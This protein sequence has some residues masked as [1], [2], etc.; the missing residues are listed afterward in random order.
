MKSPLLAEIIPTPRECQWSPGALRLSGSFRIHH[1]LGAAEADI[2][3]A[4]LL[5]G[6]LAEATGLRLRVLPTT[7]YV[8]HHVLYVG[9][10]DGFALG[11]A[12][13]ASAA[14]RD[15]GRS[16]FSADGKTGESPA[17]VPAESESYAAFVDARGVLLAGADSAGLF[18]AV[19]TLAQILRLRR[20]AGPAVPRVAIRDW[21][22]LP[23]RAVMIDIARQ[24]ER[25]DWM[26]QFVRRLAA[27]KKNMFVLYFEDKFRWGKH[28]RLSHPLGYSADEF[29]RLAATAEENHMEFVPALASLGH[30]EGILRHEELAHLREEGAIYQL[31]LRK[32]G[33]RRLLEDLYSEILPL[34]RGRYFHVNCDESPLLA[35]P[36]GSPKGYLQESIRL[37]G[38]HLVFLHDLLARH[39]KEMMMWGDML[40][41]HPEIM[42][43]L[44]R[45]I[46]VVDWDYGSMVK[47]R[48]EAPARFRREGFRV[49]V[50]P[51]AQRSAEVCYPQ[52]MMMRENIPYFLRHGL[53]AGAIGEMT[54]CWE[55]FSTN[56]IVGLPGLVASAQYAWNPGAV[57]P[58]KIASAVA[59]NLHGPEAAPHVVK[60]YRHLSSHR[61]LERYFAEAR[62]PA[63]RRRR[64]YHL[65]S[66]E[67]VATDPMV[68]LTYRRS[69]WAEGTVKQALAGVRDSAAGL[70]RARWGR[71]AL[72][73]G[74]LA[75]RHQAF[76]A[77]RRVAVNEAGQLAV[78]AESLRRQGR[79]AE[80]G[81]AL[82]EAG[83]QLA[84]LCRM[85]EAL[86][87]PTRRIWEITRPK[88]DP[89]L[90]ECFLRRVRLT[91]DSLRA[92]VA[93]L[94]AAIDALARGRDASIDA[95]FGGDPALVIQAPNPSSRLIDLLKPAISV[96]DDRKTWRPVQHKN[97]FILEKQTYVW[98][99][100]PQAGRKL[101]RYVRIHT[102]RTHID[103]RSYP[104]ADRYTVAAARTLR[105]GEILDGPPKADLETADWRLVFTPALQYER[106]LNEPWVLEYELAAI[107]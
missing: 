47:R 52:S 26:E 33:T 15:R 96:C 94:K 97:W 43:G 67:F 51:A 106:I 24:V 101:P 86:V 31:T 27:Y 63:T 92:H 71:T 95:V 105:P 9:T 104:L 66:H 77:L 50:A 76:Q 61:F 48:R 78:R 87:G 21:P 58:A 45:D 16:P 18:Y 46:I 11:P 83:E 36:P 14:R 80:A 54:T 60:A 93:R 73:V 8:N 7:R 68:Y 29:R 23:L 38:E 6:A 30:C 89:G 19:Q 98:V 81:E 49:M 55:M 79:L 10:D 91:R 107:S 13:A 20:S 62:N 44:P 25:A 4:R 53:E 34:Y 39:G 42:K 37:F 65:D 5:A 75:G 84:A 64:T 82:A 74:A 102:T 72:A 28:P 12:G 70:A 41:H 59:A 99:S 2:R 1:P 35:G 88:N 57:E 56:S 22:A 90:E 85:A 32:P 103:P 69:K 17:A 3:T 100:V 40:L